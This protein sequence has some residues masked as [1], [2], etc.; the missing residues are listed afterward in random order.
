MQK[1]SKTIWDKNMSARK[2]TFRSMMRAGHRES[3]KVE[4]YTQTD[5]EL[6]MDNE[7]PIVWD[8]ICFPSKK[9]P[10]ICYVALLNTCDLQAQEKLEEIMDDMTAQLLGYENYK[11][12]CEDTVPS[13]K[14]R[15]RLLRQRQM[16]KYNKKLGL[17]EVNPLLFAQERYPDFESMTFHEI[18]SKVIWPQ[19]RSKIETL[20]PPIYSTMKLEAEPRSLTITQTLDCRELTIELLD[21]YVLD[22]WNSGEK[23]VRRRA[24]E[25]LCH[26]DW[27]IVRQYIDENNGHVLRGFKGSK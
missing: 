27:D 13:G 14:E 12:Y 22:F 11:E 26:P 1:R 18:T 4:W 15:A 25:T 16:T 21:K 17:Y 6:H 23:I 8:D 7:M 10:K 19:V 2:K 20:T 5:W 3:A 9:Y 24:A